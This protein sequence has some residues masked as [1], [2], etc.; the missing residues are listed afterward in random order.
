M[1]ADRSRG[2]PVPIPIVTFRRR[3]THPAGQT[4]TTCF[5]R[6]QLVHAPGGDGQTP[7]HF[8]SSIEIAEFLL[9][10]GAS[11][12]DLDIDH[13]S[14]PAQY[15]VRDRPEVARYL[16]RRGC[17]T[18]PLMMAALGDLERVR[19]HLNAEMAEI[20]LRY[21]PQL[22]LL[23]ADFN[24]TPLGWAIHGSEHGRYCRTGNYPA[25]VEALL[26]AGARMPAEVGG[27]DAVKEVLK[28]HSVS[29]TD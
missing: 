26:K 21:N 9:H 12:D 29:P 6:T 18:D 28:R 14:T 8:A 15:M 17:R 19:Q 16:V 7:L 2:R 22:E 3:W 11:I 5:C 23:D 1:N 25:T 20:I 24:A 4:Q 10:H 13:E 27:T